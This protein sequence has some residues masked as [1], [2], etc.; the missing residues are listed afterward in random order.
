M[1]MSHMFRS[2]RET[3]AMSMRFM[4]FAW[5]SEFI[6]NLI[7]IVIL[8]Q[9]LSFLRL[10][11]LPKN[12]KKSF[13]PIVSTIQYWVASSNFPHSDCTMLV[14]STVEQHMKWVISRN[15]L[16]F[17][18]LGFKRNILTCRWI[19]KVTANMFFSFAAWFCYVVEILCSGTKSDR[20]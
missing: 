5:V 2:H 18:A 4:E 9:V 12:W 17:G 13:S 3:H 20:C 6:W 11:L 7:K 1:K 10:L 8:M 19:I 16:R 15:Y 14:R